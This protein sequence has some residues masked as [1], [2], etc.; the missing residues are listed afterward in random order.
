V[1]AWLSAI[2][3]VMAAWAAAAVLLIV[4]LV[5]GGTGRAVLT[6]CLSVL[7]TA[8]IGRAGVVLQVGVI[9]LFIAATLALMIVGRR[10]VTGVLRMRA[11]SLDH[12]C[13][14]RMIGRPSD[15]PDV[16][17]VDAPE[18]AA[19][20]VAGR[21]NAIV[22]TSAALASLETGTL[23]AV[24]AHE[25]AH[26]TGRHP[27]LL[28]VV[29]ALA[30]S[31]PRIT[32]FT[33]GAEAV[34]HLLEMCADDAAVRRHGTDPVLDGLLTLSGGQPIPAGA[35]G[36]AGVAVL[37]R[38]S[39]LVHPPGLPAR[40]RSALLLTTLIGSIAVVP[41]LTGLYLVTG[42]LPCNLAMR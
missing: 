22:V 13:A 2:G 4:D 28:T 19:Y 42:V 41:A 25:R 31:L 38:A 9:G 33:A 18:R 21:P 10:L 6:S 16:L 23:D 35:L 5:R 40:V 14:A 26:L 27:Q 1:L 15:R 11:R 3:S 29:R 30:A 39:R 32:L 20:C 36:A 12:A 8:A 17:I 24:L 7:G 37:A 34:A